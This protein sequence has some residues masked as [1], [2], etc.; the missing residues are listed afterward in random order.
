MCIRDRYEITFW[1]Q[2]LQ[3]MNNIIEAFISSYNINPAKTFKI[4]SD[5]GYWF[6]ATVESGLGDGSNFD[7]FEDEERIIKTTATVSV[8]GYIVNPK[9][10]G[11]PSPLRRY[12][13][14]PRV[15]FETT[16]EKIINISSSKLPSYDAEDY[17]FNHLN[18]ERDPL[19]GSAI[20]RVDTDGPE[21][22]VNIGGQRIFNQERST[23]V[24]Y[25]NVI[26][27]IAMEDPFGSST[28]K[29]SVKAKNL[30]KGETVYSVLGTLD[31]D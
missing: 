26:K 8:T 2:Y 14:A 31:N 29:A 30:S 7:S 10:P 9:Y 15:S 1:A 18:T 20:G 22:S 28:V 3:Q 25:R 6:V 23:K 11:A 16:D 24:A 27:P 19:P 13:S 21:F 5:K 4:E 17:T 12:V